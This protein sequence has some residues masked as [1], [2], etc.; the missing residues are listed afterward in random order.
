MEKWRPRLTYANVIATLA[1]FIALGGGAYAAAKL[2]NN[3]VGTKQLKKGAV[4]GQKV[5]ANTLT[6]TNINSST[7]GTVPSAA[8]ADNAAHATTA[9][10]ADSAAHADHAATATNAESASSA[11]NAGQLGGIPAAGYQSRTMWA[12]VGNGGEIIAQSGGVS[13]QEHAGTGFY[14]LHFPQAVAGKAVVV[15]GRW[16]GSVAGDPLTFSAA[17][18]GPEEADCSLLASNTPSD[19][20][21]ESTEEGT[22]K[23]APFYVTVIP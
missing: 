21:V 3:S 2:P 22:V 19:L 13:L 4:T 10:S 8:H 23:D 17:P 15:S 6:G 16:T 7:L 12:R 14:L 11:T 9:T 5:A 1:L 20:F 18:C